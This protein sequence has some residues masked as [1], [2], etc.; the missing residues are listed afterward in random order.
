NIAAF[1]SV[2]ENTRQR[3]IINLRR[4]A[5]L[6]TNDVF[7]LE[8]EISVFFGNQAILANV[9]GATGNN[10]SNV[11]TDVATHSTRN[12]GHELLPAASN[13]QAASND[14][15]RTF[16]RGTMRLPFHVRANRQLVPA[17]PPKGERR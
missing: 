15:A 6:T 12:R 8:S 1:V 3:Q 16:L 17:P 2:T 13:V 7:D 5:V 9:I 11:M 14:R 10:L 4:T